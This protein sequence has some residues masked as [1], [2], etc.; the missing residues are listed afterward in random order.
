M[1][2]NL[3]FGMFLCFLIIAGVLIA[4]CSDQSNN[5]V[6]T[7][8]PTTAPQAKYIAGDIIAKTSAGGIS[9]IS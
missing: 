4:G 1:N 3:R 8:V 2:M 9:C 7:P 5:S 6:T